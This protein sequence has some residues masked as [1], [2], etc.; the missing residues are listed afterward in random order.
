[1]VE[2]INWRDGERKQLKVGQVGLADFLDEKLQFHD[3]CGCVCPPS[4]ACPSA[5]PWHHQVS[6]KLTTNL[7][8][9][10]AFLTCPA[11]VTVEAFKSEFQYWIYSKE[12][13][14][15]IFKWV[16]DLIVVIMST[17]YSL[18]YFNL[19][20]ASKKQPPPVFT[21]CF[22]THFKMCWIPMRNLY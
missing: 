3:Q 12:E 5:P 22:R 8:T 15:I 6:S 19:P 2:L 17:N 16:C 9:D 20:L 21:H 10:S 1:M 13:R 18:L 14:N 7:E 4:S 11:G